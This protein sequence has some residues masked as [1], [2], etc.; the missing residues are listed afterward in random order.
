M[1]TKGLSA[2]LAAGTLLAATAH[3]A[4]AYTPSGGSQRPA[5]TIAPA[6][7]PQTSIA[8]RGDAPSGRRDGYNDH[9]RDFARH[10]DERHGD[11]R[12]ADA[13]RD[14]DRRGDGYHGDARRDYDRHPG[15]R[16]F[17]RDDRHRGQRYYVRDQG[18]GYGRDFGRADGRF[19]G[20]GTPVHGPAYGAPG[21][22][23]PVRTAIVAPNALVIP[24][25]GG[26]GVVAGGVY[27]LPTAVYPVYT[28]WAARR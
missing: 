24:T 10:G 21:W 15:S 22:A 17:V 25:Y 14:Y 6:I 18:P 1:L 13:R 11:A 12:Q 16:D 23:R 3:A 8:P 4:F 5:P 28:G 2:T 9:R 7:A 20:R 26:W 27:V 19:A